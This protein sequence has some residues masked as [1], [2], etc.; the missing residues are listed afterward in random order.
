MLNDERL[1]QRRKGSGLLLLLFLVAALGWPLW[2]WRGLSHP[3]VA[4]TRIDLCARLAPLPQLAG[5]RSQPLPAEGA[6]GACQ[7]FDSAGRL[8]LQAMLTTTRSSGGKDLARQFGQWRDEVRAN[9]GP[10]VVLRE[11]G[12]EGERVLAWRSPREGDRLVE[13]HGVLLSLQSKP[14]DDAALDAL[15]DAA[16]LALRKDLSAPR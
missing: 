12:A 16:K 10:A 2:H 8:M 3:L 4:E 15:V 5:L 6:A 14:M 7:W 13:D 9:E 1:R 11:S